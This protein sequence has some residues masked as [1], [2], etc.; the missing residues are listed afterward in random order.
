MKAYATVLRVLF[1]AAV[2]LLLEVLC[3][4]K[5]IDHIT[6]QPP[7]RIVLD[8]VHMLAAG[9]LNLAILRTLAN[10][11]VAFVAATLVGVA[12][13]LVLHRLRAVRDVLDP[14]FAAY[15]AVPVF[16]FYPL[17]I[18]LFGLG[19]MP[20]ILIG[21]MLAVVAVI[22]SVLSGLDRV[23]NVLLK[24]ARV[25]QFSGVETALRVTLPYVGPYVLTGARL[26]LAYALIGVVGA[27]FIMSSSG[28]GY[29]ISYAYTNFDNATMYPLILLI[30]VAS[31]GVN[32]ILG[33][34]EARL[35]QRRGLT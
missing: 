34:W 26:A 2:I 9:S 3:L 1:L 6:M 27:E 11:M 13:A 22:V 18:I 33:R 28:M 19:D 14:L 30:V 8:L 29:E 31:V 7:H 32:S 24:T 4:T 17:L 12:T 23:P 21:F 16:A 15:Y 35:M 10:S 5:V 25:N 20:E